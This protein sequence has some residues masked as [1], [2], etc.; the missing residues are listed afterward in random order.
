LLS[1]PSLTSPSRASR[2]P[3]GENVAHKSVN[4]VLRILSTMCLDRTQENPNRELSCPAALQPAGVNSN[5]LSFA[6]PGI[7]TLLTLP[8]EPP[9]FLTASGIQ[10]RSKIPFGLVFRRQRQVEFLSDTSFSND[11]RPGGKRSLICQS[12]E[13][14][15]VNTLSIPQSERNG[16]ER[17]RSAQY[18]FPI[19]LPSS[20]NLFT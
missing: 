7:E 20:T 19:F 1:R 15:L 3:L 4:D 11:C 6:P 16:I 18:L 8:N 17:N 2:S 12:F 5:D 13:V 10:S 9:F 14:L